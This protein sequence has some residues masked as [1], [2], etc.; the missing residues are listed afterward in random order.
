MVVRISGYEFGLQVFNSFGILVGENVFIILSSVLRLCV[1]GGNRVPF[2]L[3][4][5]SMVFLSGS[6]SV[7]GDP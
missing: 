7:F 2:K 1:N 5:S 6:A 3:Y 4:G